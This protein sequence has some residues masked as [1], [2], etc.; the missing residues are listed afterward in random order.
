MILEEK[1]YLE[2]FGISVSQV[3]ILGVLEKTSQRV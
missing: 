1:D 3:A 2:H